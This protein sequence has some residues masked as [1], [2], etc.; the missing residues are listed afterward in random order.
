[1]SVLLITGC[2]GEEMKMDESFVKN[3]ILQLSH[4]CYVGK[5]KHPFWCDELL[6]R[7]G[8]KGGGGR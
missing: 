5:V 8:L 2:R 1:M 7:L 6:T 4:D 3:T